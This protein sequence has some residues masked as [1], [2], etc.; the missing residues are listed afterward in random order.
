VRKSVPIVFVV[1]ALI[2]IAGF[3]SWNAKSVIVADRA[4]DRFGSW[5]YSVERYRFQRE[6]G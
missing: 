6:R 5:G 2:L 3:V 1:A 4:Q